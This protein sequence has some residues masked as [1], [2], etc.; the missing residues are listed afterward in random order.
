MFFSKRIMNFTRCL[1]GRHE[2]ETVSL[3][4]LIAFQ[5]LTLFGHG[6]QLCLICYYLGISDYTLERS[7]YNWYYF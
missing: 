3:D 2:D 4:L 6:L 5:E 7:G 1:P